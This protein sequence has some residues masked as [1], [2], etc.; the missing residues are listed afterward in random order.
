LQIVSFARFW[1]QNGNGRRSVSFRV[2]GITRD[3]RSAWVEWF[4]PEERRAVRGERRGLVGD[5]AIV[6]PLIVREAE[7]QTVNRVP[8]TGPGYPLDLD[9]PV[10]RSSL[11]WRRSGPAR[12]PSAARR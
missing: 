5:D 12:P 9:E 1:N 3:G 4:T 6:W 8:P 11:S 7:R 10:P 2:R